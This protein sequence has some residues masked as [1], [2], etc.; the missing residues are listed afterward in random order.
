MDEKEACTVE[1]KRKKSS[2]YGEW[3]YIQRMNYYHTRFGKKYE[4]QPDYF[5]N[6]ALRTSYEEEHIAEKLHQRCQGQVQA[7]LIDKR[8]VEMR[9]GGIEKLKCGTGTEELIS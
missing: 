7:C 5:S 4:D 1:Y 3:V 9:N 6:L 2:E 8:R